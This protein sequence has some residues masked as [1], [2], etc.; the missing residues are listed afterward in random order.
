VTVEIAALDTDI[1]KLIRTAAPALL[2]LP[3]V[4]PD[5]AAAPCSSSR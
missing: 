2:R 3:G 1:A 4:G 5:T